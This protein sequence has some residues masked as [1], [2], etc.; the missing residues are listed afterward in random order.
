MTTAMALKMV[1]NKKQYQT[2]QKDRGN[3]DRER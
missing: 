2:K 1:L 3:L